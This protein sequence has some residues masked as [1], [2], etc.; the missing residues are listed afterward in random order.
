MGGSQGSSQV[1]SL[2]VEALKEIRDKKDWEIVHQTG[3]SDKAKIKK[4]YSELNLNYKIESFIENM[5]KAY[6]NC[7]LVISRA[8]AMTVSELLATNTP[9]IL[10]P[11]PWATD[12][13]QE[14]NAKYLEDLGVA[15][16]LKADL[17]LIHI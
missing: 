16:V 13:H 15:R 2:V 3:Q 14:F 4:L 12:N 10:L 7:D 17:S 5:G 9:S 6:K 8:G 1:N 11:L